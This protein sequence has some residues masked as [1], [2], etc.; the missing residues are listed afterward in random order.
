M[1]VTI[2]PITDPDALYCRYAS[3]NQV[4]EAFLRLDLQGGELTA[5]YNPEIGGIPESAYHRRTLWVTIPPLTAAA[6]NTL[7]KSVKPIAQRILDGSEI[8]W[9]GNNK[10]GQF[11]DDARAALDEL[12]ERCT[13]IHF[14]GSDLVTEY[15]ADD[16][17]CED[18]TDTVIERLGLTADTT[19]AEIAA[20][21]KTE[22]DDAATTL[23]GYGYV[24]LSGVD[25][26]LTTRREEMREEARDELARVAAQIDELTNVRDAAIRRLVGWKDEDNTSMRIIAGLAEMSHTQVGR[27]ARRTDDD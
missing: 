10:V 12:V 9:D 6:A 20:L 17:Y 19:D 24:I 3:Q 4:Q 23:P 8:T 11:D 7:M 22:T 26:W 27:I 15:T 18:G 25:G 16:W 1:D 13:D 14:D 21:A 5:D 2:T